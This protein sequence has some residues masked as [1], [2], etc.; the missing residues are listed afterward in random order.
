MPNNVTE[1]FC[2]PLLLKFLVISSVNLCFSRVFSICVFHFFSL[3]F[4]VCWPSLAAVNTFVL[5]ISG[6]GFPHD[7]WPRQISVVGVLRSCLTLSSVS[8]GASF[9]LLIIIEGQLL[10]DSV[11]RAERKINRFKRLMPDNVAEQFIAEFKQ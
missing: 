6:L 4:F 8:L 1:Q 3:P 5:P 9:F 11:L 2:F 10:V 7:L